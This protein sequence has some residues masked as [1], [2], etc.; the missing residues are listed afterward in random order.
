MLAK[1]IKAVEKIFRKT[2]QSSLIENQNYIT[3]LRESHGNLDLQL[4]STGAPFFTSNIYLKDFLCS[5]YVKYFLCAAAAPRS[6]IF[7]LPFEPCDQTMV[8]N[9]LPSM[10]EIFF[11]SS[12]TKADIVAINNINPSDEMREILLC[13]NFYEIP[14]YPNN[15]LIDLPNTFSGYL[16]DLTRKYRN[17]IERNLNFFHQHGH[18]IVKLS[19]NKFH[20]EIYQAYLSARQRAKVKWLSYSNNYFWINSNNGL[21]MNY[22]AALSKTD[23]FLGFINSINHNK[24]SYLCRIGV[25]EAWL[26]KDAIYFCLIYKAIEEAISQG[27][28]TIDLGPTAYDIKKRI[29]AVKK[30]LFNYVLPI[31]YKW[32]LVFK[33]FYNRMLKELS[34]VLALH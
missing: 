7:G 8:L 13:N 28:D 24:K 31:K 23:Q 33:A 2:M 17:N 30:P 16:K 27:S 25:D 6:T 3:M 32:R 26:R 34:H 18:R 12:K 14:S 21:D 9:L 22:F 29:G 15:E 5:G 20:Q 10:E 19:S 1:N 4:S 11:I